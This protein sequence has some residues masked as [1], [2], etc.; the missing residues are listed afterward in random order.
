[1]RI[2]H[3]EICE[4]R[5]GNKQAVTLSFWRPTLKRKPAII[6]DIFIEGMQFINE[7]GT[8]GVAVRASVQTRFE[9]RPP[10]FKSFFFVFKFP[11]FTNSP[12]TELTEIFD[13]VNS[14][15]LKLT[16]NLTEL[17]DCFYKKK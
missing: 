10:L 14:T 5:K 11:I 1:M 12:L 16:R 15:K 3:R 6:S 7:T 9:S 8:G 2:N 4:T 13:W 17:L